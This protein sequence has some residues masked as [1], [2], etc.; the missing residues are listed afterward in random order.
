MY[1]YIKQEIK[2]TKQYIRIIFKI[3]NFKICL[4]L[5]TDASEYIVSL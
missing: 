1:V 3:V 5:N 4:I 2:L